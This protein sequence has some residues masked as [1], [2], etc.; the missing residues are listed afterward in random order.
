MDLGIAGKVAVVAAGSRGCGRG[1]SEALAA[2][3]TKVVLTGRQSPIVES[4]VAAIRGA[5]GT[6]H[7]V[8]ADMTESA[9]V[10]S[11]VNEAKAMF[12]DPD[13]LVVNSPSAPRRSPEHLRGV[14]NC[15]DDD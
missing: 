6:A 11:I 7:G 8:V 5:G 12:G 13:I 9:G 14:E 2:E 15:D 3:G 10:V 4:A 1:I